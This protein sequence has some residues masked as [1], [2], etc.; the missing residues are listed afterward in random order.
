MYCTIAPPSAANRDPGAWR[1]TQMRTG[2]NRLARMDRPPT[3]SG[4]AMSHERLR[5]GVKGTHAHLGQPCWFQIGIMLVLPM[6]ACTLHDVV[7]R[8]ERQRR[9]LPEW[10][11]KGHPQ[12][13]LPSFCPNADP[14]FQAC[15]APVAGSN[16][17]HCPRTPR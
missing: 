14:K 4:F 15:G 10:S 17:Y 5:Q 16:Y 9:D 12:R 11:P 8:T 13:P 2:R 6:Y 3:S 1:N 7:G